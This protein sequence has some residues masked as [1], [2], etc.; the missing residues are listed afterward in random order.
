MAAHSKITNIVEE[1]DATMISY[2]LRWSQNCTNHHFRA[3]RLV[4]DGSTIS[5]V[6]VFH[7]GKKFRNEFALETRSSIHDR[8]CWFATGMG[9][10]NSKTAHVVLWLVEVG[11]ESWNSVA[12]RIKQFDQVKEYTGETVSKN[13]Q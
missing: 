4:D 12:E 11:P 2:L 1:D 7:V 5:V 3:P 13:P 6:V 9:I 10:N 8:A